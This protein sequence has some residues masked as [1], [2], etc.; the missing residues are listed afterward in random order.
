MAD[1]GRCGPVEWGVVCRPHPGEDECGDHWLVTA[2]DRGTLLAAVDGLGHGPAAAR[3]AQQAVGVLLD[4][5][6]EPLVALMLL[7]HEALRDTRGA[8]LTL[9]GIDHADALLTWLGVGNVAAVLLRA[10]AVAPVPAATALLHAGIVGYQLPDR[11][12]AGS[13]PLRVGDLLLMASDGLSPEYVAS[14]D[15]RRSPEQLACDLVERHAV[16]HDD[17]LLLAARY[18]P[19]PA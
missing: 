18:R 2:T 13:V 15:L 16:E 7:C 6:A 10:G 14:A 4:N 5:R 17:A 19:V 8:A 1:H 12:V 11:L 3:V 9:A